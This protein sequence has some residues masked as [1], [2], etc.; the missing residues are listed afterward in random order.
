MTHNTLSQPPSCIVLKYLPATSRGAR[1]TAYWGTGTDYYTRQTVRIPSNK[2]LPPTLNAIKVL[3]LFL[4]T[5]APDQSLEDY[6]LGSMSH[7][8]IATKI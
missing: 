8:Y 3:E 5:N 6:T 7:S 2:D 1:W 4:L